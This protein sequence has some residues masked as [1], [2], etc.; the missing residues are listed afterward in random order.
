MKRILVIGGGPREMRSYLGALRTSFAS[1]I[2][3][4]FRGYWRAWQTLKHV[5]TP[6]DVVIINARG[7]PDK[8]LV[9]LVRCV[10]ARN[11]DDSLCIVLTD[12]P[13]RLSREH[14]ADYVVDLR[15]DNPLQ[16]FVRHI[17]E[18]EDA[19]DLRRAVA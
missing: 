8:A 7:I 19:R 2:I 17:L 4:G 9:R 12:R 6:Y 11:P 10:K 16:Q 18:H 3:L 1:W 15:T 13:F 5:T 14:E